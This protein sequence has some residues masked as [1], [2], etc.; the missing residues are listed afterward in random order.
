[1]TEIS[2][3]EYLRARYG[4]Q[5]GDKRSL[6]IVAAVLGVIAVAPDSFFK[7]SKINR[8]TTPCRRPMTFYARSPRLCGLRI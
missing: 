8:I 6:L 3:A 2:D 5:T 1:M 4:N 7:K